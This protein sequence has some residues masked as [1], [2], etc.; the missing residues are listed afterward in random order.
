M[1]EL[2]QRLKSGERITFNNDGKQCTYHHNK[3]GYHATF[4]MDNEIIAW[5]YLPS[6]DDMRRALKKYQSENWG[7]LYGD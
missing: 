6:D 1:E 7:V 5:E 2:I 4:T 3:S